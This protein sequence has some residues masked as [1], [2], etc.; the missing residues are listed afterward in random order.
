MII[1]TTEPRCQGVPL[2]AD[3]AAY[4]E[5][6]DAVAALVRSAIVIG[7]SALAGRHSR[8]L[9]KGGMP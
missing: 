3:W 8:A 6:D 9:I 7:R 1:E 4:Y 2:R 5:R